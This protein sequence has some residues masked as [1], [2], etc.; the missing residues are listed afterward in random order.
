MYIHNMYTCG[1]THPIARR[2][3]THAATR[4]PATSAVRVYRLLVTEFIKEDSPF[5]LTC[6][7]TTT[8]FMQRLA[9]QRRLPLRVRVQEF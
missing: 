2:G 8:H 5:C 4:R 6:D 7:I 9:D 1:G 3:A